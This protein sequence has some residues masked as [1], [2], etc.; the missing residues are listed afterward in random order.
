MLGVWPDRVTLP[1]VMI[2]FLDGVARRRVPVLAGA[3]LVAVALGLLL[4]S[5]AI[6][7]DL[8]LTT[9]LRTLPVI[10]IFVCA[11]YSARTHHPARLIARPDVP[12]F[13]VPV[14]PGKVLTAAG[15]ALYTVPFLVGLV[16]D[17]GDVWIAVIFMPLIAAP[18]AANAKVALARSGVRLTPDGI[19][20]RGVFGTL[21]V[22]WDALAVPRAALPRGTQHV[23]LHLARPDLV[24]KRG[25]RPDGPRLLPAMGVN[26]EFL[27]RA[28]HEYA[29][30]PDLR[31]TI[32]STAAL[33]QFQAIPQVAALT[34]QP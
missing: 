14:D 25:Y 8:W 9:A 13:D 6:R 34:N 10:A 21:F 31:P 23:V 24:R 3:L 22:P 15:F 1:S 33:T 11:I 28:I 17:P 16:S 5:D 20:D 32:G 18:L 19:E 30:R 29:N 7:D 4:E 26:T 12:A 27:A 2:N